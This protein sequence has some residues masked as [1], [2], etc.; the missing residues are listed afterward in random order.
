MGNRASMQ[1][2]PS[3]PD[4]S[5]H[6][7]WTHFAAPEALE[8]LGAR[9]APLLRAGEAVCLFGPLGAGKS[10]LARG[11]VRALLGDPK[12][13]VP[14][15][16][17]T[18]A[19]AYEVHGLVLT[20]FDLYRLKRAE[21]AYEIG[22]DEALDIGAV[23]IEW[24]ERLD[25]ALPSDRLEIHLSAEPPPGQPAAKGRWARMRGLGAWAGRLGTELTG[26]V[27]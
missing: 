24:S 3:P 17:F 12:A 8:G 2:D 27:G 13:E 4:R 6:A 10:T 16:T 9:I 18:L 21:E 15:P 1:P 19:Q 23:V 20:H 5:V 25:G 26:R 14:S 11:L 7:P 22:L